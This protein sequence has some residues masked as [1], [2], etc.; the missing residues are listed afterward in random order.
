MLWCRSHSTLAAA[1]FGLHRIQ[2]VG[3]ET[4]EDLLSSDMEEIHIVPQ[5]SGGKNGGFFQIVIGAALLAASFL[6][7]GA[8]LATWQSLALF[9]IG[10]ALVIGGVM[11]LL[12]PAPKRDQAVGDPE[13]SKYLGT[14]GNTTGSGTRIA[15]LYGRDKVFGHILSLNIN[16]KDVAV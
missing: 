2:V 14:P 5:L 4:V 13:A 11:Q 7:P 1:P 6:V 16:A 3:C 15:V 9:N 8:A 12:A 10:S